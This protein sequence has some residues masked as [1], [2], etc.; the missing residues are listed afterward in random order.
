MSTLQAC[1]S[2]Q[3]S[4]RGSGV[5]SLASVGSTDLLQGCL[6]SSGT[7]RQQRPSDRSCGQPR[8][9]PS[10]ITHSANLAIGIRQDRVGAGHPSYLFSASVRPGSC[11]QPDPRD[12]QLRQ[13]PRLKP[14]VTTTPAAPTERRLAG[15][16]REGQIPPELAG[17][18]SFWPP[19]RGLGRALRS[20]RQ[21]PGGCPA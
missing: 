15:Q 16:R 18:A 19:P 4:Y 14:G 12:G 21:L 3:P 11:L 5:G 20:L 2:L 8:R 7:S 10:R 17:A 9:L 6:A 13:P 1:N